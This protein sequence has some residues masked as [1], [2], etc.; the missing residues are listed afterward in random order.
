MPVENDPGIRYGGREEPVGIDRRQPEKEIH[1]HHAEEETF[2]LGL[3][4]LFE[5]PVSHAVFRSHQMVLV[6]EREQCGDLKF[7]GIDPGIVDLGQKFIQ[8]IVAVE[9]AQNGG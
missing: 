8:R 9:H 2:F 7:I 6:H 5:L 3:T 4:K 1:A